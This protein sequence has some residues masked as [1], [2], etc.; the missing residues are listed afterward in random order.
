MKSEPEPDS[1][2]IDPPEV[3]LLAA[4]I[5]RGVAV[6]ACRGM[7]AYKSHTFSRDIG[8]EEPLSDAIDALADYLVGFSSQPIDVIMLTDVRNTEL[9]TR[10]LVYA[11][12]ERIR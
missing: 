10:A 8:F 4:I 2:E 5:A 7:G 1:S 9:K 12:A 3:M 6:Q 11:L